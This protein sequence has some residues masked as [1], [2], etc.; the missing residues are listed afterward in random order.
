MPDNTAF[1][2]YLSPMEQLPV[3]YFYA[4]NGRYF[5]FYL[6]PNQ[7][8]HRADQWHTFH[9]IALIIQAYLSGDNNIAGV[10]PGRRLLFPYQP[11]M[12]IA[13]RYLRSG[14]GL[15]PSVMNGRCAILVLA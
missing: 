8:I 9:L 12:S 5:V 1:S 10:L 15:N 7:M 11:R 2:Q 6:K 4:K 14:R 13:L 3:N